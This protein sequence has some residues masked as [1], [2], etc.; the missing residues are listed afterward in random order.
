MSMLESSISPSRIPAVTRMLA[1]ASCLY[2][3]G[4]HA[5][6]SMSPEEDRG[7]ARFWMTFSASYRTAP[8]ESHNATA[9]EK[10]T[11]LTI[12]PLPDE[13][14]HVLYRGGASGFLGGFPADRNRLGLAQPIEDKRLLMESAWRRGRLQ[15]T[16]G[17]PPAAFPLEAP[18]LLTMAKPT[19]LLV[20]E[21][22]PRK[23]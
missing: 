6:G 17:A 21:K 14:L 7:R 4:G 19:P 9:L 15:T 23:V 16:G 3:V 13:H 10:A 5:F 22:S 1:I 2:I 12:S 18:S 20:N 11:F 8:S